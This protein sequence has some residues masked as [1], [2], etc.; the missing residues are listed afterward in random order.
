MQEANEPPSIRHSKVEP[1]SVEV[2]LKSALDGLLGSDGARRDRRVGRG[3]VHRPRVRLRSRLGIS[4]GV[5]RLDVEGVGAFA[6]GRVALRARAGRERASV[7]PALEGDA[8]LAR[9]EVEARAGRARRVGGG[10]VDR[11]D[12]PRP[13]DGDVDDVLTGVRADVRGDRAERRVPVGRERP[14][15]GVGRS[16]VRAEGDPGAGRAVVARVRAGEELDAGDVAVGARRRD[17]ERVGVGEVHEPARR[18][19]RDARVACVHD[20]RVGGRR[21]RR[22]SRPGRWRAR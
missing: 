17:G 9:A 8:S 16:R 10:R 11:C 19:D 2:K 15:G 22:C 14:R 1:P 7:E 13:V 18:R 4:G 12:R 20:P 5:G 6:E 3:R 21:R